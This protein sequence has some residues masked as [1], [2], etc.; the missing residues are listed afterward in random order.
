MK[1]ILVS[2]REIYGAILLLVLLCGCSYYPPSVPTN[3]G[4]SDPFGIDWVMHGIVVDSDGN[5]ANYVHYLL[6][7]FS[8]SGTVEPEEDNCAEMSLRI[9]LPDSFQYM[10]EKENEPD[11][12]TEYYSNNRKYTDEPYYVVYGFSYDQRGNKSV[13]IVIGL[14]LENEYMIFNW[15]EGEDLYLVASTDPE[16]DP[17]DI[18]Q[19]FQVFRETYVIDD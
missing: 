9:V 13:P 1:R 5:K 18:L 8:V 10:F 14:S 6:D 16:T 2:H 17:N 11:A 7:D 12:S 15:E 4:Q 3:G 19:Y